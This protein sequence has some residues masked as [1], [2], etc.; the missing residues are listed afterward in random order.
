MRNHTIL[1]TATCGLLLAGLAEA[2]DPTFE[3][4]MAIHKVL[5][6]D[7]CDYSY[8][9]MGER[10]LYVTDD[11]FEAVAKCEDGKAYGYTFDSSYTLQERATKGE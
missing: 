3:E 9:G 1:F 5:Q 10:E 11:G 4:V 6:Q 7:N 8:L 2:R